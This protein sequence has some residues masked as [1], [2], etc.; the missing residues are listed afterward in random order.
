MMRKLFLT[1]LLTTLPYAAFACKLSAEA[2]DLTA[3]LMAKNES[4]VVFLG[5]VKSVQAL[6]RTSNETNQDITFEAS[7]WWRGTPQNLVLALGAEDTM[8]GTDC[9]GIFDFSAQEG[10]QWLVVGTWWNG[11]I[12]PSGLLSMRLQNGN[13]P[14]EI[15][16]QLDRVSE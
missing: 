1:A 14:A 10:E 6:P 3:F 9:A 15:K 8:A 11:K 5:K 7:K 12:N 2:T 16:G 13:L 4:Q